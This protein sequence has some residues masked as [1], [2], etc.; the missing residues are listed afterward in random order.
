M[1]LTDLAVILVA[2]FAAAALIVL[3]RPLFVR[4]ALARPNTRSSQDRKSVV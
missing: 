1:R 3:M 2:G 4:Y